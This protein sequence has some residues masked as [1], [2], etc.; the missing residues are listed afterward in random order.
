MRKPLIILNAMARTQIVAR[1]SG[2]GV[3]V[4]VTVETRDAKARVSR[5]ECTAPL[6]RL[7][8]SILGHLDWTWTGAL[9]WLAVP[10]AIT[11]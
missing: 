8:A 2:V 3:A 9:Y 10:G 7:L 4:G 1:P 11:R 6:D 5:G